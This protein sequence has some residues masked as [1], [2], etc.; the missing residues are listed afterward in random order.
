MK[1]KIIA[2]LIITIP[3]LVAYNLKRENVEFE[4]LLEVKKSELPEDLKSLKTMETYQ[5]SLDNHALNSLFQ[6]R[7]LNPIGE[8]FMYLAV[9]NNK[10]NGNSWDICCDHHQWIVLEREE[11]EF[12]YTVFIYKIDRKY[13]RNFAP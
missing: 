9:S 3:V 12:P 6:K 11:K 4:L 10:I 8:D 5:Y 2:L 13:E 1:F 7:G